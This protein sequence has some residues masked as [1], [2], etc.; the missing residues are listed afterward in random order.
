[1]TAQEKAQQIAEALGKE[2]LLYRP[3]H[4]MPKQDVQILTSIIKTHLKPLWEAAEKAERLCERGFKC[5]GSAAKDV[6]FKMVQQE[7]RRALGKD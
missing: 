1:M 7:L 2:G 6:S 4:L 3:I 5:S